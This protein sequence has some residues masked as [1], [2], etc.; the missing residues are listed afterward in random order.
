MISSL[1]QHNEA[2]VAEV[3]F[4]SFSADGLVHFYTINFQGLKEIKIKVR[5][6]RDFW[7]N[8]YNLDK[9]VFFNFILHS[10]SLIHNLNHMCFF[11]YMLFVLSF[12]LDFFAYMTVFYLMCK[13]LFIQCYDFCM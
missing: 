13:S 5:P 2:V 3:N 1:I 12:L 7:A 9:C 11:A 4:Y 10:V 8:Q 6:H